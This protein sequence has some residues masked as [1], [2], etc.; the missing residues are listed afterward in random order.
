MLTNGSDHEKLLQELR[1]LEQKLLDVAPL[2]AFAASVFPKEAPLSFFDFAALIPSHR[3]A[4]IPE[5][6]PTWQL[7]A[8][9]TK[10]FPLDLP[11]EIRKLLHQAM[12]C[13]RSPAAPIVAVLGLLN[14]GKSSLVSTYL[15][16]ENRRRRFA[17]LRQCL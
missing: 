15:S 7:S 2:S 9:R 16:D 4:E 11:S 5:I 1:S 8:A 3:S 14:A 6:E 10:S 12:R 17:P 13:C